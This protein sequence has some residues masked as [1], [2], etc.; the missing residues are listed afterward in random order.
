MYREIKKLENESH[1]LINIL[2]TSKNLAKKM[3]CAFKYTK[4]MNKIQFDHIQLL[5]KEVAITKSNIHVYLC[6]LSTKFV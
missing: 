3:L 6:N 1:S 2:C 4:N 5:V